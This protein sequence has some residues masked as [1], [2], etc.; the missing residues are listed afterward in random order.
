MLQLAL[1]YLRDLKSALGGQM[2]EEVCCASELAS[3]GI[4]L[5][6]KGMYNGL[7]REVCAHFVRAKRTS[8]GWKARSGR[9][10][11]GMLA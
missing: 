7:S 9:V 6:R 2:P 3:L 5:W 8:A 1:W 4:D 11:R 10:D